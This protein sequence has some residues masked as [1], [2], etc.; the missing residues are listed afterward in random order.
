MTVPRPAPELVRTK[1][2]ATLGPAS[3]AEEAIRGL[4]ESGVDVFRLN[5]AH[6]SIPEHRESLDRI[7]RVSE[8]LARPI[9]VLADLAGPK[10]RLGELPG[11]AVDVAEGDRIRFVRGGGTTA[12]GEFTVTYEPL[13]EELSAGDA[14]MIADGTISLVVEEK[15]A[16]HATCR[17]VQGGTIRSRQGVNLPG[18]KLS[19]AAMSPA[20]WQHAEWAASAGVDFVSLSF[21]RSAVEVK[22]L[23]ELLRTRGSQARV[24]AKIEKREAIENLESIVD[25]ADAVMVAR[26]DLGVEIDVAGVPMVQKRI[27]RACQRYQKPV[28]VATQMLDSMQHARRPT[29]AEATDVA[30]AILDGADACM[31]SGETAIGEHPRLAVEMMRRIARETEKQYLADRWHYME[32]RFLAEK[33][34]AGVPVQE[35][36]PAP[37]FLVEGLHP[38]TQAVVDGAS[39]IAGELDAR[40]FVVAS[41]S[42][43]TAI[44]RSKRRGA[45]PT[46]GLSD[47]PAA[48]RQMALYWGV[49]P[50]AMDATHDVGVLLDRITAWGLAEGRLQRGDRI[51]LVAGSG[52]G[53][54]GHNMALVHEV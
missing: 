25:A 20:D 29:R 38:I 39:R 36:L 45:V 10:I 41:R 24:V 54:G 44:A 7:R 13:I 52:F 53:T 33:G 6:G 1:I 21:V 9:G 15:T 19:V 23:K 46:V 17:V 16:T 14:V 22:L 11:G 42:G 31:L 35:F 8:A 49:T 40:L 18:V 47:N 12:A 37:E 28:I 2:V 30:N 34:S 51:L 48:L 26:G 43:L 27:I 3:R 32:G 4:V 5:M 50:L